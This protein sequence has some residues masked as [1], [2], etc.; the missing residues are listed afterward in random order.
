MLPINDI[1]LIQNGITM[2][3]IPKK[4][5][6]HQISKFFKGRGFEIIPR[7]LLPSNLIFL[8]RIL[9]SKIHND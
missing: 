3:V 2:I 6:G 9:S 5:F 8:E 7:I 4:K 1:L